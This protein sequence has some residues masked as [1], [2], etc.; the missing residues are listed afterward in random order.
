MNKKIR[1]GSLKTGSEKWDNESRGRRDVKCDGLLLLLL[2]WKWRKRVMCQGIWA[3]SR[4]LE[5]HLSENE[6][7]QEGLSSNSCMELNSANNLNKQENWFPLKATSKECSPIDIDFSLKRPVWD[8]G[9][10][11]L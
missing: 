7:G 1:R 2:C 11:E 6:Q 10:T 9:A 5:R 4:I 8:L 3:V